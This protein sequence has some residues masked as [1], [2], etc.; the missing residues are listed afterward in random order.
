L[1]AHLTDAAALRGCD[2]PRE[3]APRF[4]IA[5]AAFEKKSTFEELAI[6]HFVLLGCRN[7]S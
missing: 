2:A 7:G 6:W 1:N 5:I 4:R 3:N